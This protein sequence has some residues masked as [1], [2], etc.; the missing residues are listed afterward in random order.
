MTHLCAL[1][2]DAFPEVFAASRAVLDCESDDFVDRGLRGVE[3]AYELEEVEACLEG[4]EGHR[5]LM[6]KGVEDED[7]EG[8][9]PI[10]LGASIDLNSRCIHAYNNDANIQRWLM[11]PTKPSAT[12]SAPTY[13][14][15]ALPPSASSPNPSP[16]SHSADRIPPTT[17][18]L[19]PLV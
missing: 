7:G 17:P 16:A 6:S 4:V 14:S 19:L 12:T 8:G 5:E 13:R 15:P 3:L 2:D 1:L 18:D 10:W 9:D 11:T